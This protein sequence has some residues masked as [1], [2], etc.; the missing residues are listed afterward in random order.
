MSRTLPWILCLVALGTGCTQTGGDV[1]LACRDD[2]ECSTGQVCF[3]DGCGD[4]GSNIV[5]EV[6]IGS[7]LEIQDVA[8]SDLRS[9]VSF[10]L[11]GPTLV[12]GRVLR[13]STL[14]EAPQAYTHEIYLSAY[15]SSQLLPGR[16]RRF[17]GRLTPSEGSYRLP[18]GSGEFTFFLLSKDPTVPPLTAMRT[19]A[20]G[21]KAQLDFLIPA[22]HT[23]TRLEGQL[24]RQG[25]V[26]VESDLS[27]E[28]VAVEE[29]GQIVP[30]SQVVRVPR[31]DNGRFTLFLSPQAATQKAIYLRVSTMD[32]DSLVL[33]KDFTLFPGQPLTGPLELGDYG[34][35][36]EVSG[37]VVDA[38]GQPLA[39]VVVRMEGAV[40]GGGHVFTPNAARTSEQ[41][42]FT[43]RTL[44]SAPG[45]QMTLYAQPPPG[46]R[47]GLGRMSAS[48]APGRSTPLSLVVC[49][50]RIPLTGT[51]LLP[52][53]GKPA[54]MRVQAVPMEP[55]SGWPL[56]EHG[57][58]AV[59]TDAEG[60]FQLLVD[61]GHYRLDFLPNSAD[62]VLSSRFITV[63]PAARVDSP[64]PVELGSFLLSNSREVSGT[65]SLAGQPQ[66][67]ASV[68][69]FRV[70][71]LRG[72]PVSIF[73]A[74]GFTDASGRYKV[75][76]PTR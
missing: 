65:V 27:V 24:V 53:H 64:A 14:P 42:R 75:V 63:E 61:P 29:K 52:P 47:S 34:E 2:A 21:A 9:P 8:V 13:E 12:Y 44:P 50:D 19:V 76:L 6:S 26:Q 43:L 70:G 1:Q 71:E 17:S 41:G 68:R 5:A 40:N 7:S 25:Q 66:A 36:V 55:V 51:V 33:R 39:G 62:Q 60:G 35:P 10:A 18:V 69:F 37:Q 54:D 56:P 46:M 57:Q 58:P 59:N 4:P 38:R 45:T 73:L 32:E 15:G 72:K 20:P 23:L 49:P 48:V 31:S 22:A 11:E 16:P 67:V 74:E 30:L 28:A 3:P